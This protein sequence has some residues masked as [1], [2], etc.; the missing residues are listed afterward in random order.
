MATGVVPVATES[1]VLGVS[2][3]SSPMSNC[4][5]L[6]EPWLTTYSRRRS[7]V[8]AAAVDVRPVP[9]SGGVRGEST[10]A[11]SAAYWR[12]VWLQLVAYT[13]ADG[14]AAFADA[15]VS[16]LARTGAAA[17]PGQTEGLL[18]GAFPGGPRAVEGE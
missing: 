9:T 18:W 7:G 10:P 6:D 5:M 13:N 11:S 12:A 15:A 14:A 8:A 17:L 2:V 4:E 3:P 16:T 1:G